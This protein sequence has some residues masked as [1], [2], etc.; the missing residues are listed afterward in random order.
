MKQFNEGTGDH[1]R[2]LEWSSRLESVLAGID[3]KSL[4]W[5]EL[6]ELES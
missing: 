5:L 2:L 6:S 1:C 3:E 4:R